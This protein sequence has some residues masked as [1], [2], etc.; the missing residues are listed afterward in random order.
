MFCS[1]SRLGNKE[2]SYIVRSYP[3]L[4]FI[5]VVIRIIAVLYSAV[6]IN[7]QSK[8]IL[9]KIF[10]CPSS[11]YTSEVLKFSFHHINK[12]IKFLNKILNQ[13]TLIFFFFLNSTDCTS[14]RTVNVW[15]SQPHRNEFFFH[16]PWIFTDR[17]WRFCDLW[18][19][20]TTVF[21]R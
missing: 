9:P 14:R 1:Y 11:K 4:S 7:D 15:W 2:D 18:D 21:K 8:V 12:W 6:R 17:C 10:Q 20:F 3:L 16:H 5:F 19:C 13:R